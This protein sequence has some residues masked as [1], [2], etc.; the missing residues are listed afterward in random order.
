MEA[1]GGIEPRAFPPSSSRF[2]L[3]D[4][5]RERGPHRLE[6]EVRFEL[7]TCCLRNSCS[8]HL[9]LHRLR[10]SGRVVRPTRLF[11]LHGPDSHR[12]AGMSH[13]P[14]T[15]GRMSVVSG[16]WSVISLLT[17]DY[18]QLTNSNWYPR[19]DSNLQPLVCRT[20]AP[21]IELLGHEFGGR[22]W[23]RTNLSSFSDSR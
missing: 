16:Q 22:S 3:E 20:S 19:K 1:R 10:E 18:G 6:A 8:S 14:I 4:R 12:S 7:T 17:T 5:C 13:A 23:N 2:G 21:S 15:L 11:E 9:K